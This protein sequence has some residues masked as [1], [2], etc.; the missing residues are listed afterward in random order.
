MAAR[1]DVYTPVH[2][3]IA[4]QWVAWIMQGASAWH[5]IPGTGLDLQRGLIAWLQIRSG[6]EGALWVDSD[7]MAPWSDVER[8]I[9]C[10]P[11]A[12][13]IGANYAKRWPGAGYAIDFGEGLNWE[14]KEIRMGDAIDDPE[15]RPERA[16]HVPIGLAWIPTAALVDLERI[17]GTMTVDGQVALRAFMPGTGPSGEYRGE[18]HTFAEES[19][20]VGWPG[21]VDLRVRAQHLGVYPYGLGDGAW[22]VRERN[23][24]RVTLAFPEKTPI[25]EG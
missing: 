4:W 11:R 14:G 13:W 8:M 23:G 21:Y 22:Q 6:A 1:I 25:K 2:G 5:P 20:A 18:D 17:G 3:P 12:G 15:Y 7:T 9:A 24:A 10:C 19:A 16:A